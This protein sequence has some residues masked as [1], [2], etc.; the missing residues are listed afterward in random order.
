MAKAEPIKG[1]DCNAP[2]EDVLPLILGRRLAEM[3][4]LRRRALNFND[5]EGVHDMRVSSRRLR[6]ALRDF[7]P[8]LRRAKLSRQLKGIKALADCLG[9]VRDDDVAI[10]ALEK[11]VAKAPHEL[12][13]GLHQLIATMKSRRKEEQREL[14]SCLTL[15]TLSEL[16][17]GFTEAL[18]ASVSARSGKS[19]LSFKKFAVQT[20]RGRIRELQKL[21]TSLHRP[22]TI[23]PLHKM[24]IAAKRLR[25]AVELFAP[26][27]S[28]SLNAY[29][30]QV[31]KLQ[32]SLGELHDCDLW[33]DYCGDRLS[34]L[35]RKKAPEAGQLL[36][37]NAVVWLLGHF[38]RL[39][40]KHFRAALEC[41]HEWEKK[42]LLRELTATLKSNA[43]PSAAKLSAKAP[44]QPAPLLHE[45][46]ARRNVVAGDF[47]GQSDA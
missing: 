7:A 29:A 14:V 19:G 42:N 26:C 16:Q 11:L 13:E 33:I 28:D 17:T 36:E 43:S 44:G 41:W 38:T 20:I 2:V 27:W 8:H 23:K 47:P 12:S 39:R 35:A 22:H 5:P 4:S 37:L 45:R 1:L 34:K 32:A 21:S 46:R 3:I 9:E 30:Q 31:A 40:A 6:S 15:S 10:I 25:Y 18:T 24:R